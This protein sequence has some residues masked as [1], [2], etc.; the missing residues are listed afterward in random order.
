MRLFT[1]VFL[2]SSFLFGNDALMIK[3]QNV[4]YIQN[5]IAIEENISQQLEKYILTE[6]KIP[7][8]TQLMTNEYLG[9][10][11]SQ[12][13][14]LGDAIDFKSNQNLRLK[15]AITS[16]NADQYLFDLYNRDLHRNKT[17]S[18]YD[19]VNLDNSYVQLVLSSKEANTIYT[20]LSNNFTISK[21]C[22]SSLV[23]EYCNNSLNTIRWYN[24]NN[25]WIEYSKAD[26]ENANVTIQNESVLNDSKL[27]SLPVGTY[28]RVQ[29][30]SRYIKILNNQILKVE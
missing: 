16:A 14:R 20:I 2:L 23:S 22:S 6:F 4:L 8:M 12:Q 10:N 21:E 1:F 30:S 13:N 26:F 28:I 18:I 11:F 25:Y 27:N 7:S 15:Y 3:Q 9:E 17:K 29:N 19:K 24:E 5:M